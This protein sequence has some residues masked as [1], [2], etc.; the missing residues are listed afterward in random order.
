MI[1]VLLVMGDTRGG[2]ALR[3]RMEA[4]HDV[5]VV[6]HADDAA[7]LTRVLRA[8]SPDVAVVDFGMTCLDGVGATRRMLSARPRAAVIALAPPWNLDRAMLAISVGAHANLPSASSP[9]VVLATVRS[10]ADERLR[11][12]VPTPQA[13]PGTAGIALTARQ[14]EVLE[15]VAAGCSNQQISDLLEM[16]VRSVATHVRHVVDRLGVGDRADAVHRLTNAAGIVSVG[17]VAGQ[18]RTSPRPGG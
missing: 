4:S 9:E 2:L 3:R 5:F 13:S 7:G 16:D 1:P 17:V 8:S 15:L 6:G 12:L 10:A 11:T 18:A 14:R